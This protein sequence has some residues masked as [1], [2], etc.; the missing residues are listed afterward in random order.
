MQANASRGTVR[1]K[2]VDGLNRYRWTICSL[3]FVAMIINYIDRQSLALLAPT[4]RK[5]FGWNDIDYSH[6]V[7]A[8]TFAYGFGA[9]VM[10]RVMDYLGTKRGFSL[11]IMIWSLAEIAHAF[12]GGVAGFASVRVLLGVGEAGSFPAAIKAV[13]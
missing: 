10:G 1:S 11:S 6:I 8:F 13:A 9:I 5:L 12:V 4:L 2:V 3:L 7:Q